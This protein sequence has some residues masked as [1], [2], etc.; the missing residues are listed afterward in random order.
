M[1]PSQTAELVKAGVLVVA[2][3]LLVLLGLVT[4]GGDA[5]EAIRALPYVVGGGSL[6][7]AAGAA[8]YGL[9]H[10]G[11]KEPSSAGWPQVHPPGEP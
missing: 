1:N 6:G 8:A 3:G 4:L 2:L 9:R 10:W 11:A 5:T 7:G